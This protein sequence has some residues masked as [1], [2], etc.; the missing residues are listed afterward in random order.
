MGDE[1]QPMFRR[2]IAAAVL[3]TVGMLCLFLPA[4]AGPDAVTMDYSG[5]FSSYARTVARL[6]QEPPAMGRKSASAALVALICRTDGRKIDFS[7]V[8]PAYILAGPKNCFT[9]FFSSEDL[10]GD[11]VASLRK[12]EGM[13]YAEEDCEVYATAAPG[14]VTAAQ[15]HSFHSWGAEQMHIGSY[16]DY[17]DGWGSGSA[18]IAVVDSGVYQHSLIAGKLLTS[19][20]DYVD[21]DEDAT[22][23]LYGHGTGVAGIIADCTAGE[24]VYILPIRV[25]NENGRGKMSNVVNA[26]RE[27]KDRGVTV[28]NL[29]LESSVMSEAL[30]DAILEAVSAGITVVAA[31][32]NSGCD[33]SDICPA[34]LLDSGVIVVGAALES[35]GA[36]RRASYSNY[37]SSVDVYAF[38]TG[39]YCCNTE[40]G[41]ASRTGTSMAAPHV[42]ALSAMMK[43]VYPGLTPAQIEQKLKQGA[44]GTNSVIVPDAELM[45]PGSMGFYLTSVRMRVGESLALPLSAYPLTAGESVSLVSSDAQT[46]SCGGGLLTAQGVGSATVTASCKGLADMTFA[47]TVDGG[48]VLPF[49]LPA[50]L[51]TLG[52]EAFYGAP[53][54]TRITIP[55]TVH[56]IGDRAFD[57]C[58]SLEQIRIPAAV[59]DIGDNTFSGAVIL[60]PNG[61]EAHLYAAGHGLQY[62]SETQ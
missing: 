16:I 31:A 8:S 56:S 30:D 51:E 34:H 4:F 29:S 2:F 60:C 39:I 26:V 36:Y 42:S 9:L 52:E 37:G 59:T 11:A 62:I 18:S 17:A 10:C 40:G 57:Q 21:G 15:A 46:V 41:Y 5:D 12:M 28:I 22:N 14:E 43:L 19:G 24:P 48:S 6:N 33:T 20:Y 45:V 49:T 7:A 55:D 61:S 25:L 23:D 38:G 44:R 13:L 58:A 50:V 35:G 3:A 32:G 1:V 27:A 54:I 53:S 47:V